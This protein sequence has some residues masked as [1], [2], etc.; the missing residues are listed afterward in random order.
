MRKTKGKKI[1]NYIN[2][3]KYICI[4]LISYDNG[5]NRFFPRIHIECGRI[6]FDNV[7]TPYKVINIPN[8]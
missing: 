8:K 6:G 7:F 1:F 4:S 3:G 2:K 5:K